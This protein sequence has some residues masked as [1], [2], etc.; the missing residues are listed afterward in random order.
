MK[1]P[2]KSIA[3]FTLIKYDI[4]ISLTRLSG[5]KLL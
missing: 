1:I 4:C 2:P 5:A 3:L